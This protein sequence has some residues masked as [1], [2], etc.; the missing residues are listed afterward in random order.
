M[1]VHNPETE[2]DRCELSKCVAGVHAEMVKETINRLSCSAEQ[3]GVLL[4][5]VM[6][7]VTKGGSR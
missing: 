5:A 6:E 1:V 4:E 3:K 7:S 2:E